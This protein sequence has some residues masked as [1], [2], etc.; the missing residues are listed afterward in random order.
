MDQYVY[1]SDGTFAETSWLSGSPASLIV[2]TY[3]QDGLVFKR[4]RVS[5]MDL[6]SGKKQWGRMPVVVEMADRVTDINALEARLAR[7]LVRNNGVDKTSEFL[8]KDGYVRM[9]R[10]EESDAQQRQ[11]AESGRQG[12]PLNMFGR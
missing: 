3:Q 5:K 6:S 1:F 9:C 2:G 8:G 12:V 10:R 7:I 4:M 11:R